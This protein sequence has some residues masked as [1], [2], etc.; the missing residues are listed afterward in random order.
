MNITE[1][2]ANGQFLNCIRLAVQ[3]L[4]NNELETSYSSIIEAMI[5][6]P[7]SPSPHNLLGIWFEQSGDEDMARRHFRA[8]YSL[9]PTYKPA[10]RNLE[11]VCDFF[12]DGDVIVY[13]YGDD[14]YEGKTEDKESSLKYSAK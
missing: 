9:D 11:R 6:A 3:K 8:A 12:R 1:Q 14:S 7:S 13:D 4:R 5:M 2:K 10:C